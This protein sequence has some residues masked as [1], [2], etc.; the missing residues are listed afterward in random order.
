MKST[1]SQPRLLQASGASFLFP[2]G[3]VSSS[4]L[5]KT[6]SGEEVNVK[7]IHEVHVSCQPVHL[8]Y[9]SARVEKVTAVILVFLY[10]LPV[11]VN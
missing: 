8:P 2:A 11:W 1:E 3:F 6:A 10:P 7:R 5:M 4:N 9:Q